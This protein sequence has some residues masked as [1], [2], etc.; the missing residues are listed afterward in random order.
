VISTIVKKHYE[1]DNVKRWEEDTY[2]NM[3][4]K[5]HTN[6]PTDYKHNIDKLSLYNTDMIFNEHWFRSDTFDTDE[7]GILFLGCSLTMGVGIESV[8]FKCW[9]T[10]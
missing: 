5:F 4:P 6:L 9:C 3:L 7:D 2:E 8:E 1:I 10:R